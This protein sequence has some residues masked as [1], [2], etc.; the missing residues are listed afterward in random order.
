M[1]ISCFDR[2]LGFARKSQPFCLQHLHLIISGADAFQADWEAVAI[3]AGYKDAS[4]SKA[5]WGRLVKKIKTNSDNQ[6]PMNVAAGN[7]DMTTTPANTKKSHVAKK[8]TIE[9]VDEYDD[10]TDDDN[11]GEGPASVPKKRKRYESEDEPAEKSK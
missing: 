5:M 6:T 11:A 1:I 9:N 10:E 2:T 7:N 4:N 8:P 3:K